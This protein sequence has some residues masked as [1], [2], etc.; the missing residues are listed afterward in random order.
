MQTDRR[1]DFTHPRQIAVFIGEIED[2]YNC[3]TADLDSVCYNCFYPYTVQ[4]E[5]SRKKSDE[6]RDIFEGHQT[7]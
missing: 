7:T 4:G 3:R 5:K 1:Q 2:E 6:D